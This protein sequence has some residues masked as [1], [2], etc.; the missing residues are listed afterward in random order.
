MFTRMGI[1][2]KQSDMLVVIIQFSNVWH[3]TL[4]RHVIMHT[5]HEIGHCILMSLAKAI[6]IMFD[7]E[8]WHPTFTFNTCD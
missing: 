5:I 2:E 1:S 6:G 3:L 8:P 4:D 7:T